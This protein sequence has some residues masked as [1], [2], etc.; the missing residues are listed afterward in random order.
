MTDSN[1]N[2]KSASTAS[3]E[4]IILEPEHRRIIL[5]HCV[6]KFNGEYLAE[7]RPERRR[8]G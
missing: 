2:S 8:L 6:R 5:D 3:V 7:E 4:T 1:S